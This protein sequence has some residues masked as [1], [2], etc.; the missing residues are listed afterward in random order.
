MQ[1]T[2]VLKCLSGVFVLLHSAKWVF[3]E[4]FLQ[5]HEQECWLDKREVVAI[6]LAR[7]GSKGIPLKNLAK[8]QGES[9]LMRSLRIVRNSDIFSEI[10]VSTDSD[11]IAYEAASL[12]GILV[13]R[14]PETYALDTTSSIESVQEFL[15]H[16][17]RIEHIAL[18]Q[19]TSVFLKE[20]YLKLAFELFKG[21]ECVFS[22]TRFL[23]Y[24]LISL[25]TIFFCS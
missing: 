10:W 5:N 18:I 9:L 6:I 23:I 1:L 13:H 21:S 2:I 24:F 3:C 16:H 25:K 4:E 17:K 14:R 19:C 12:D 7:G 15:S 20:S 11:A 8:F 22:V